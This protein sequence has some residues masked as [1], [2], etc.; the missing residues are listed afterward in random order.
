MKRIL[1]IAVNKSSF[2]NDTTKIEFSPNLNCIMGGRGTGKSTLLHFLIAT[3]DGKA[4]DN[5]TTYSILKNNLGPGIVT[6]I[7]EDNEGK[8]YKIQ[9]SIDELPQCYSMPGDKLVSYKSIRNLVNCDFYKSQ[10]IEEIGKNSNDRLEL[11]DKMLEED[12]ASLLQG[13]EDIKMKLEEN[14]K[15][16]KSE[17]LRI[18]QFQ[19]A[20]T[21]YEGIDDE[22][23]KLLEGKPD[24]IDKK[25]EQKFEVED[26][27]EKLRASE[28][29][30]VKAV[31]IALSE[32]EE[33]IQSE[34]I[35]LNE[36]GAISSRVDT[37]INKNQITLIDGDFK[38]ALQ[39][40][41]KLLNDASKVITDAIDRID[42]YQ[43]KLE[44]IHLGQQN[45]FAKM[46]QKI[47]KHKQY[48][49]KWNGI[50]KRVDEKN[51]IIENV[52]K[53][54]ERRNKI[55]KTR[56]EL[57]KGFIDLSKRLFEIRKSKVDIIN[58]QFGG[59]IKVTLK[60]GAITD[61]Y[62]QALRNAL[63][64]SNM[65]YNTLV[66]SIV[67]NFTPQRFA[68]I[69]HAKD[70]D[71]LKKIEN[72]DKERSNAIIAA[73]AETEA[74]YELECI[75]CPD[76]PEFLLKIDDKGNPK[77]S[78]KGNYKKSEDLSTGQRCTTVLPII[79]AVSNNPLVIDQPE[80]NLDNK[81]IS[82]TIHKIIREQKENR[83]LIFITHN[84]NIPVLSD[85]EH[86]VFLAYENKRSA[87]DIKGSI[88]DVKSSILNLM[89]G[90]KDAFKK[91]E[92]LYE[93]ELNG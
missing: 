65:K 4:E 61:D 74:L 45:E 13:M 73:L 80:D 3:F 18:R 68:E 20:I 75:Y 5:K 84:P 41:G 6:V 23:K 22:L 71:A 46:K 53:I 1:S 76:Y 31:N 30:Y 55:K 56:K 2:F 59:S 9:K 47:E 17:N 33:K 90:G 67:E 52:K 11:I 91:R 85:A 69:I 34:I 78:S 82:D 24:D 44:K 15:A 7:M 8:R 62:D 36:S 79:F 39:K 57:V 60:A 87:V 38:S 89:E 21:Q 58:A 86:N 93:E 37:F 63:K 72:I 40:A 43:I 48:Y 83:Q 81:Y 77:S 14:A 88:E 10:S 27:N 49:T 12:K 19:N 25:E 28:M 92:E 70:L 42:S 51:A 54:E 29:R 64:G 16:I 32:H 50:T 26:K 66:N 35:Q